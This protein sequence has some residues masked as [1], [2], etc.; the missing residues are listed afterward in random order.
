MSLTALRL[1]CFR[2]IADASIEPA[3]GINWLAGRNGSGKTSVLEAIHVLARGR[4][5]RSGSIQSVIQDGATTLRVVARREQPDRLLGVERGRREW[6]GRIDGKETRRVSEFARALPLVLVQPDSHQ[7]VDGGP[8]VRR[9]FL[10]WG[11]FHVEHDYLDHWRRYARLLRQ[12]NAALKQGRGDAMLDALEPAMAEAAERVDRKRERYVQR[13]AASAARVLG[14]VDLRVPDIVLE[15]RP[16]GDEQEGYACAL[17]AS[18]SRD[19]EQGFTRIGPHRADL[20]LRADGRLAAP[21]LSR[22]QQKLVALLL[23]LAELDALQSGGDRPLLL[24]DDPVSELDRMHFDQLWGWL[25]DQ[26]LQAWIAAVEHPPG[27]PAAMFHVEQGEIR[28]MV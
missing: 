3:P 6:R 17:R 28:R 9:A 15:Y 25:L 27:A 4:S 2:N 18:R 12:R 13:L 20:S 22:G 11:L 26:D 10:D 14:A 24:L 19:R 8:D 7:L 21:R 16:S 5:F 23:K 1:H